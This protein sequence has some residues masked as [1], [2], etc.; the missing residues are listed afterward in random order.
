MLFALRSRRRGVRH[1]QPA[2]TELCHASSNL[3][4]SSS[5]F[6]SRGL[7]AVGR[8]GGRWIDLRIDFPGVLSGWRDGGRGREA[9]RGSGVH[10]GIVT[11][12]AAAYLDVVGR[13]GDGPGAGY[14]PP[15]A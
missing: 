6:G 11:G 13:G 15:P 3:L 8:R 12:G 10:L 7:A 14:L 2:D 5:A 1:K 9:D 4:W